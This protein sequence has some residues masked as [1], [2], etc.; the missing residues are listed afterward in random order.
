M[1]R[2]IRSGGHSH[3]VA[4]GEE[5]GEGVK[6]TPRGCPERSPGQLRVWRR[7]SPSGESSQRTPQI[8]GCPGQKIIREQGQRLPGEEPSFLPTDSS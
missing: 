4:M 7:V 6:L 1:G 3:K 8:F 5:W 2:R